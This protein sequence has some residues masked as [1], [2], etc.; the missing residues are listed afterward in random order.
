MNIASRR[1]LV[2]GFW[3][4]A[5][6]ALMVAVPATPAAALELTTPYPVVVVEPGQDLTPAGAVRACRGWPRRVEAPGQ[7]LAGGAGGNGDRRPQR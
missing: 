3:V 1:R 4:L 6:V 7:A 2:R 5:A